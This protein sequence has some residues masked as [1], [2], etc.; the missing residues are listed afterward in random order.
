MQKNVS[1]VNT[2]QF[3]PNSK[4]CVK[5]KDAY[6]SDYVQ[7]NRTH[8]ITWYV[9]NN[10]THIVAALVTACASNIPKQD[11]YGYLA[12]PDCSQKYMSSR[13][14]RAPNTPAAH[15]SKVQESMGTKI[16]PQKK[17]NYACGVHFQSPEFNYKYVQDQTPRTQVQTSKYKSRPPDTSPVKQVGLEPIHMY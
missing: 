7:A 6:H 5:A 15:K 8:V 14:D 3:Q 12:G 1:P 17:Q 9:S 4:T 11:T 16:A 10:V 13:I 2:T